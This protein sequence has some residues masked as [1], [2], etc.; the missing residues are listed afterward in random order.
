[1]GFQL[2]IHNI[3]SILSGVLMLGMAL[4]VF[5]NGRRNVASLTFSMVLFGG[6]V[7]TVSHFIGVNI[8][9]AVLSKD[10]LMFNLFHFPMGAVLI[11]SVLAY[12]GKDKEKRNII[13]FAYLSAF[14]MTLFFIIRPELFLLSS[15]PKMYFP[16]YYVPGELNWTRLVFLDGIAVPYVLYLLVSAYKSSVNLVLR[17]QYYYLFFFIAAAFFTGAIANFLVYDIEIDPLFGMMFSIVCLAPFLYGA[18]KYELFNIKIIATQALLY[19]LSVVVVGAGLSI[20]IYAGLWVVGAYPSFPKWTIPLAAS[21]LVVTTGFVVWWRLRENDILKYEFITTVTHKFRTPLTQIGWAT[22]ALVGNITDERNIEQIKNIQTANTKMTELIDV[23]IN[24]SENEGGNYQYNIVRNSFSSIL[25]EAAFLFRQ[26]FEAKNIKL[27]TNINPEIFIEC[28]RSKI[29]FV[30][31]VLIENAIQYTQR[32]GSIR[33]SLVREGKYARMSISDNGIGIEKNELT[34]LF[35]K[36]YRTPEAK[37]TD[38]EGM[39][40]GLYLLKDIISKHGGTISA[41]SEGLGKGS[42]F[43]LMMKLA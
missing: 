17:K 30:L 10:V 34:R 13:L 25:E 38:T 6:A 29:V 12:L 36:F 2:L 22:D 3:V 5:I 11:H 19:G 16:N 18:I 1:M 35:T 43:T 39:G 20:L 27:I 41:E 32:S 40:I 15:T 23:L 14:F 24:V 31:Q 21:V 37:K 42:T 26:R 7:F 33:V 28:D 9:D 4:S 8:E